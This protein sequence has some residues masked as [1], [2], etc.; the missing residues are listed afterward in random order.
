MKKRPQRPKFLWNNAYLEKLA[1]ELGDECIFLC[2]SPVSF[3]ML[4]DMTKML[5]WATRYE[6]GAVS[7]LGKIAYTE[8]NVPCLEDFYSRLDAIE[9]NNSD[10]LQSQFDDLG[11]RMTELEE[12]DVIVNQTVNSCG[13]GCDDGTTTTT[14]NTVDG[15]TIDPE[16]TGITPPYDT[17]IVTAVD[18][19]RCRAANYLA[20]SVVTILRRLENMGDEA[21][22]LVVLVG[23]IALAVTALSPVI[24]DEVIAWSAFVRWAY[25]AIRLRSATGFTSIF[26]RELADKIEDD[27][28]GFTCALYT[29]DTAEDLGAKLISWVSA[30]VD[31]LQAVANLP[32]ETVLLY[33]DFLNAVYGPEMINW[34]VENIATVAPADFVPQYDCLCGATGDTCPDINIVLNAVG[35][36]PDGDL[37]GTTQGFASQFNS[38]MGWHEIIFELAANYCVTIENGAYTP[39]EMHETCSDG[40]MV[41]SDGSCIRRFVARSQSPFAT[42][43][44]FNEQAADCNCAP[45]VACGFDWIKPI[46]FVEIEDGYVSYT[47]LGGGS[48]GFELYAEGDTVASSPR[49]EVTF[50]FGQEILGY[51]AFITDL[52]IDGVQV[53]R[54]NDTNIVGMSTFT[55]SG[56]LSSALR[57]CLE[58]EYQS[59]YVGITNTVAIEPETNR[60]GVGNYTRITGKI[61]VW[62]AITSV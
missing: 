12:M 47:D 22:A 29:W 11:S 27:L 42:A 13:C 5:L 58:E 18:S 60:P 41:A 38:T 7:E 16:D 32:S 43:V 2:L 19:V 25:K 8:L 30:G 62:G 40:V 57:S 15:I 20:V 24:G 37:T 56:S 51:L 50:V 46:S 33:K 31:E 17:E 61:Q 10:W 45:S 49:E 1:I 54:I 21:G 35:N 3:R 59:D 48:Y 39:E 9:L 34:F 55:V 23:V 6:E 26:F 14:T 53:G 4:T 28:Q 52:V 36:I 44:T